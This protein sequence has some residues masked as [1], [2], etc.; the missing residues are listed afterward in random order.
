[1][2]QKSGG[3][4]FA[5]GIFLEKEEGFQ[6]QTAQGM[7]GKTGAHGAKK[8]IS[9]MQWKPYDINLDEGFTAINLIKASGKQNNHTHKKREMLHM[10]TYTLIHTHTC[11]VAV[12]W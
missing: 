2:A 9:Q 3:L 11:T 8:P 12:L 4:S 5:T 7:N 1:M 10:R 6:F